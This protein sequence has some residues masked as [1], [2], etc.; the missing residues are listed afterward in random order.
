MGAVGVKELKNRLTHYLRRTKAGEE[1]IV[2]ER[3]KPIA[4]LQPIQSATNVRS[5][6]TRLAQLEAQ[7]LLSAPQRKPLKRVRRVKVGGPPLS[8]I[9]L[10]ERR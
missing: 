6:E 2:T 8:T 5:L 4:L 10:D 3:G 1:V 9:I 7:G